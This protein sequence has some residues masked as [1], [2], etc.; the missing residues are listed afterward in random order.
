MAEVTVADSGP[1][2]ALAR[3]DLLRLLRDVAGPVLI[4]RHV[5][6]ELL[7]RKSEDSRRIAAIIGGVLEIRAVQT[8][9]EAEAA[10]TRNL[11]LGEAE[12]IC[13]AHQLGAP[14]FIDEVKGRNAANRLGTQVV[15][16]VAILVTAKRLELVAEVLPILAQMRHIGYWLADSLFKRAAALADEFYP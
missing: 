4:P 2:I 1:L 12:A 13:L 7:A 15:G 8:I 9:T 5:E 16:T 10:A 3:V 14:L 6:R 11:D